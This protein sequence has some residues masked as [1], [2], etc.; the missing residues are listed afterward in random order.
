MRGGCVVGSL[1]MVN[2]EL[3]IKYGMYDE[4]IF[5][6]CEETTLGIMLKSKNLKTILILNHNYVHH[7]SVSLKKSISSD[8]ERRKISLNSKLKIL[9]KYYNLSP[10]MTL[11]VKIF[12]K[13]TLIEFMLIK[14]CKSYLSKI[15]GNL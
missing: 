14:A 5:L 11:I 12:F 8:I 2:A 13:L 10:F 3:M 4:D 9:K 6:F 15:K 7:H 1:L